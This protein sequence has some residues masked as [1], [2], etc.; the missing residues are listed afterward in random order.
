MRRLLDVNQVSLVVTV[1]GPDRPGLV[2]SLAETVAEHGGNW[3]ESRM[4]HLAG[5]FAG[6][7]R[8]EVAAEQAENLQS[9][10]AALS[11]QGIDSL[12]H[13]DAA[14]RPVRDQP[15][16]RLDLVGHDRQ[17]IVKEITGVLADLQANVE[18]LETE[19]AAA[20]NT[21]QPL[22]RA[23]ICLRLP[24]HIT[25]AALRAALEGVAADLMVDIKATGE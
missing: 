8:V 11:Q 1:I 10:I 23:S 18:E 13:A 21:G 5:Q 4:A 3:L 14:G 24:S 25:A 12:V 15:T 9:A 19:A 2:E 7:L 16:L 20:A 6:I 17:G 22:F